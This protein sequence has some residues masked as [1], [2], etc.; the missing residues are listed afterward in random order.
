MGLRCRAEEAGRLDRHHVRAEHFGD[1]VDADGA[2]P[3]EDLKRIRVVEIRVAGRQV[4]RAS[5]IGA[6]AIV[7]DQL[8]DPV[9]AL[10][11]L[12]PDRMR[13]AGVRTGLH[14]LDEL[15]LR[16]PL[17]LGRALGPDQRVLLAS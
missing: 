10:P 7:A 9:A 16:N 15:V 14:A 3:S 2:V 1:D 13:R 12:D 8:D 4:A 17:P 6:P 5:D 11:R